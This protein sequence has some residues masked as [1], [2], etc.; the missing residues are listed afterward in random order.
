M[1]DTFACNGE[2]NRS[3]I[4]NLKCVKIPITSSPTQGELGDK[5]PHVR[6][7]PFSDDL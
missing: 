7:E 6:Y 3:P 5:W 2:L 4:I 1:N